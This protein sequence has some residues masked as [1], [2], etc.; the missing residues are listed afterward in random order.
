MSIKEALTL[1]NKVVQ[2]GGHTFTLR[3]PSVADLVEAVEQSKKSPSTFMAWLVYN[4]LVEDGKLVF[5]NVEEVLASD[6]VTVEAISAEI[7]KL[8]GAGLD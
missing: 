1:K 8:Y 7:D 4:D 3:R 2:I 5:D 6:G